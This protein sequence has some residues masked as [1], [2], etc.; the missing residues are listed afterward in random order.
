MKLSTILF[1]ALL[2]L[3][4]CQAEVDPAKLEKV[5]ALKSRID[6]SYETFAQVDSAKAMASSKHYAENMV[7]IKSDY[8]DTISKEIADFFDE[9]YSIRKAMKLIGGK[10]GKASRELRT[11]KSRLD[12][13]EH[14]LNNDLI[15]EEQFKQY[16]Q[17]EQNNVALIEESVNDVYHAYQTVQPMYDRMNPRIDS[18]IAE[19]KRKAALPKE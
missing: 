12:N 8:R 10:Y 18:L 16:I 9:Y 19:S 3:F 6:S 5:D 7:Y 13:L 17:L 14:D 4:A 2:L 11:T 15:E 1:S